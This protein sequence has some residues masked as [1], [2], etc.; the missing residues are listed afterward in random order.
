MFER[1]ILTLRHCRRAVPVVWLLSIVFM[2]AAFADEADP[3]SRVA[4]LSYLQGSVSLQPAG[5]QDWAG[6]ALNRP[7]TT[8]DKLWADQ[9]SRAELDLG[10]AAVRLGAS[11]GVSFLNLD[12]RVAQLNVTAGSTIVHLR[13]L[14]PNQTFEI[15]TPN[16]ALSLQGPGDY[17]VDVNDTG[18]TTLVRVSNGGAQVSATGQTVPIGAQQ[19]VTF[20]GTDQVTADAAAMGAPDALDEWSLDRERQ[21]QEARSN[22]Y[23]PPDMAGAQDLDDYGTWSTVPDYGSVWTP[24]S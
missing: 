2:S 20:T 18:D 21:T 11:T 14:E 1:P 8:G 17:R 23:V 13:D 3:P 5:M 6:A 15:D 10:F 9:D 12:D 7:L 19:A 4:R 24:N 22:Q 16:I